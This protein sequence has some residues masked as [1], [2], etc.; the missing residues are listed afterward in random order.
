[1][2]LV[3]GDPLTF[4]KVR[5]GSE[6]DIDP[7]PES[8]RRQCLH[9]PCATPQTANPRSFRYGGPWWSLAESNR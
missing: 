8:G 2:Q 3:W 6:A 4:L 9:E 5:F 1:M 7:R